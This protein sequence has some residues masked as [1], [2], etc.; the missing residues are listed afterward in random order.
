[1]IVIVARPE[2]LSKINSSGDIC[3][4]SK[5]TNKVGDAAREKKIPIEHE[6]G[7]KRDK[8]K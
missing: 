1:M 5:E 6:D 8:L 2:G 3:S 7:Q 4:L